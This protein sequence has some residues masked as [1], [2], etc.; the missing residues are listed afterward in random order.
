MEA[1]NRPLTLALTLLC[2]NPQRLTGLTS[3]YHEFVSWSL[4]Q[5]DDLR[6]LVYVGPGQS[7]VIDDPRITVVRKYPANDHLIRRILSDLFL[8]AND[9]ASR[10]AECL[11]TTGLCPVFRTIPVAMHMLSLQHLEEQNKIGILR[12]WYRTWI[13]DYGMSNADLVITN[14]NYALKR[15]KKRWPGCAEKTIQSYEGLQHEVFHQRG[16]SDEVNCLAKV[17][18]LEPGYL[19]WCSNFYPY[20]QAELLFDAYALLDEDVRQNHPLVMVGGGGW[21]GLDSAKNRADELGISKQVKFL[22]WVPD[23]HLP[24]LYRQAGLFCLASRE[25]T[26]GRCV[27]EAL[28]CGTPCVVNAIEVM[29]EAGGDVAVQVDFHDAPAVSDN[30]LRILSDTSYRKELSSRGIR[31]AENFSFSKL[32]AE[33]I[34]A[35]RGMLA[36]P[37]EEI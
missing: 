2:E 8:V 6:W 20:K 37:L 22:G 18:D 25:E 27:L 9:A 24:M 19:F 7:W 29:S 34:E 5:D 33:R 28:A 31:H 36:R 10:G 1:K 32:A 15:M 16:D 30:I 26:F 3:L 11:V 13:A 17:Y 23:E 14:T 35:I 4:K 21:G 12:R